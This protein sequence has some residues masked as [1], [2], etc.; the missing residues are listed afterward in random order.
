MDWLEELKEGLRNTEIVSKPKAQSKII[1]ESTGY[2]TLPC[3]KEPFDGD[4]I[5]LSGDEFY[6]FFQRYSQTDEHKF[7]E[8][9]DRM[10]EWFFDKPHKVQV[11]W[12][13]YVLKWL[14]PKES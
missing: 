12:M 13:D 6:L 9:L 7:R 3:T 2:Y 5:K 4:V 10:D 14:Q 8:K 11:K 1:E